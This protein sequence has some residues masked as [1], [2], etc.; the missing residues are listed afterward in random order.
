YLGRHSRA[1][2]GIVILDDWKS[3]RPRETVVLE[4]KLPPGSANKPKLSWD[5]KRMLFAFCD[6]TE[7]RKAWR[8]FFI[9]E[10]ALDG[11]WVRQITGTPTDALERWGGR[12]TSLIE[13]NDPCYLPDSGVAFV[14]TR[15]QSFGR[16]HNGRYTPSLLLHRAERDGSGLRQISFGEANETD[17]VV[18]P[19]GRVVYTR[20]EYV[21]RNVTKFH[22]LWST[23]PDGTG[24]A[25]FYGNN[26]ER[27]WM[28]SEAV[29]IPGSRRVVA[30]AT[31]HH[32]FSTGSIVRIDPLIGQD[33]AAPLTRITP[34]VAFFEAERYAGGGCYSTPWPLTEDLFLAA[35]SPSPIPGQGRRPAD[36]YAIYLVDSFG[37]RELVYRDAKGSCFSPT[38]V[39]ARPRPATLS[40]ALPARAAGRPAT[41]LVQDVYL[42]MND[43]EGL[44]RRGDIKALRINELINQPAVLKNGGAQP[45]LVRHEIPK[46]IL[47]TVPVHD[48]GSAYFAAP[49]GRPLQLQ[50]LDADGMAVM[51]MRTFIYLQPGESVACAGC[52]EPRGHVPTGQKVALARPPAPIAP[53]ATSAYA[54]GFSYP[55]S[56]QP[57]LDRYC[58]GCHGLERTDDGLDLTGALEPH[59]LPAKLM[60]SNPG[61]APRSYNTLFNRPGMLALARFK[62]ESNTSAPRDYFAAASKLAPLLLKGHEKVT[63]DPQNLQA[64]IDWLDLNAQ[65]FGDFSWNRIEHRRSDPAGEK[66]L[67]AQI[68]ERF[69]PK[70][71]AQP[72]AA[73]VNVAQPDQSRILRGPLPLDAGGWG[74]LEPAWTSAEDPAYRE[75]QE[76]VAAS[77]QPLKYHDVAGACGRAL[78]GGK[79][80]CKSC[81]VRGAETAFRKS[82]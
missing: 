66:A 24:A 53:T 79:C 60:K 71:A 54:G 72:F 51:T 50:A 23:R 41:L 21:N 25:N 78:Q 27:P 56:V 62:A 6:H 46:K 55:R 38:P 5:A 68:A 45:S 67:R 1:G 26:T 30:L 59:K 8:R 70:L 28:I 80:I 48:D 69:G 47:G 42:N 36:D 77:I 52:H 11:S 19:D 29:P 39:V 14:S 75:M 7:K 4:G 9:Y 10:A 74:Q 35:W 15:C 32:S 49:P 13:D 65:L 2:A 44:I 16:C 34:E 17:P 12:M 61:L 64:V 76:R 22:M 37:G 40:S 57:V 43:P 58:I 18:L 81:W 73:L 33:D 20:W 3:D 31:G 63:L 82:E